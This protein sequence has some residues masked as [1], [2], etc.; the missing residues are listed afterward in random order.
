V[1]T[2]YRKSIATASK[3]P[4]WKSWSKKGSAKLEQKGVKSLLL[5]N[6]T[7]PYSRLNGR[8]LSVDFLQ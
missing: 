8:R 7:I 2:V 1:A 5:T 4:A 3:T 6:S